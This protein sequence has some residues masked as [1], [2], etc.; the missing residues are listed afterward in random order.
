MHVNEGLGKIVNKQ[1]GEK[2]NFVNANIDFVDDNPKP[3]NWIY[4][5]SHSK[6]YSSNAM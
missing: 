4:L 1:Y 2:I 5:H 6:C 3:D